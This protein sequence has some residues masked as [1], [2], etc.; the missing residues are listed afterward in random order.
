MITFAWYYNANSSSSEQHIP[1]LEEH[2]DPDFGLLDKVRANGLIGYKEVE[3]VESKSSS[4]KRNAA[5]MNYVFAE[6]QCDGL[7]AAL[8]DADQIHVANYLIADGGKVLVVD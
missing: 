4:C 2:I 7:I 5:L 8:R 3:D 1:F 6:D